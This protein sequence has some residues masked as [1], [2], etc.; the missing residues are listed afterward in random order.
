M[1]KAN[2]QVNITG[3]IP[4]ILVHLA[5]IAV[6]WTGVTL[7]SVYIC[8]FSYLIRMWAITAGYH[9]YFSHKSYKTSRI[10]QFILAFLAQTSLQRGVLTWA[11][12][13]RKHHLYSDT[14]EDMHSPTVH[15]FI[16]SH[17]GWIFAEERYDNDYKQMSDFKK[18][19]ELIWLDKHKYFPGI[20]LAILSW[21]IGGW[22]GLIVGFFISTVILFHSTFFINSIAHVFG[23]QRYI[24]GDFS[25]NNVWLAIL[26]LGEG[27]H[28]N[29]H[30]YPASA[31][32]GFFWWEIDI[33]YY[34]LKILE[35]CKIIWDLNEPKHEIINEQTALSSREVNQLKRLF[36]R[37][38]FDL[39]I[40]I[41]ELNHLKEKLNFSSAAK[42]PMF[43][44]TKIKNLLEEKNI[45][46]KQ[47]PPKLY[48]LLNKTL[49]N[50]INTLEKINEQT[51]KI[52]I[53]QSIGQIEDKLNSFSVA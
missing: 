2:P 13:H 11:N 28:N 38:N 32:Q 23:K 44:I 40:L 3:A 8:L 42:I 50:S 15:G 51:S 27:W 33:T 22:S 34:V 21:L 47:F 36:Q 53:L 30:Y 16:Y 31:R 1:N 39:T 4:F 35:K 43:E 14:Y 9:R 25:R 52:I 49:E 5:C 10:F 24:T 7:T 6:F 37:S 41:K 19:P 17:V 45:L 12:D 46:I 26:T 18:F 29:H 48:Q 20:I